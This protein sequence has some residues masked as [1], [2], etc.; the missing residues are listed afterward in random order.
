MND[1]IQSIFITRPPSPATGLSDP[2]LAIRR[3]FGEVE[4]AS[5]PRPVRAR[6][7]SRFP[8][9]AKRTATSN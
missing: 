9:R 5:T 8:V 2:L 6:S 4:P 7:R 3:S 1:F